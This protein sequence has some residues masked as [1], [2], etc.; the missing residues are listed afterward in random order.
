MV[1]APDAAV[2]AP[3]VLSADGMPQYVSDGQ[4]MCMPVLQVPEDR[5]MCNVAAQSAGGVPLYGN[6]GCVLFQ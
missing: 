6:G 5:S 4:P 1:V 3:V 2:G